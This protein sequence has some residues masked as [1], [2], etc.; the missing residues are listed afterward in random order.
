MEQTAHAAGNAASSSFA[1]LLA[2][3]AT[4]QNKSIQCDKNWSD[5]G[6][7][8]DVVTLSYEQA[9]RNHARYRTPERNDRAPVAGAGA[10][11]LTVFEA[12]CEPA[13]DLQDGVPKQFQPRTLARREL[14]ST[15]VTMHLSK[16]EG[17]QLR[18][19]A[20]EAGLTVSAY[21]R[22]CV[23]EA[24]VLREQ[25][26]DTLAEL[27]NAAERHARK[28]WLGWLGRITKRKS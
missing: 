9:L 6:L 26:K 19:R 17:E 22:S 3:L 18:Q 25:V 2:S 14:R 7:D 16:M 24:D 13:A 21:L 1:G 5:D 15:R 12:D 4:P 8:N 27:R 23:L 10:A 28:P 20:A 11:K